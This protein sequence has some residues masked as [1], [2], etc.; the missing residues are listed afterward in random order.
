MTTQTITDWQRDDDV[1]AHVLAEDERVVGYGELWFDAEENEVELAR[2]IVAPDNRGKGLGRILVRR[3]LAQAVGAGYSDV[4]MRVH[5]DNEAALRC[6]RGAGFMPVEA[7]LAE[8]WNAAQPVKYVWLQGDA[9]AP[10]S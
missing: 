6:Y 7:G 1:Q 2:I 3:L 4:F 10:G 9:E 5:P 8:S